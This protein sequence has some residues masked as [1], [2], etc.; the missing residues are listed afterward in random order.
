MEKIKKL[1]REVGMSQTELARL[2]NMCQTNYNKVE[3]EKSIPNNKEKIKSD[4]IEVLYPLLIKKIVA[5][6]EELDR[7]ESFSLQ[8]NR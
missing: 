3:N 4:A 1:R 5:Q 7:L 8:F 6:R 2:I